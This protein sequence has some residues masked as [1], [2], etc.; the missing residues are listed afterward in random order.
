MLDWIT[1]TINSLGY[2]GIVFLMFLENLFPPIPSEVI[3]PLAG[4][5]T[6]QGRLSITFVIVAGTVGSVL[7]ALL[8][9]YIGKSFG[10]KRL[11]RWA[12]RH[13]KWLTISSKDIDKSKKWFNKYGGIAVFIGR[14]IPG[15]RTFISVPA[16]LDKMHL[17]PFL[18]YSTIGSVL[19]VSLL[20]FAGYI[21][22]R[23]YQL[24][25]K[26]LGPISSFIVIAL[27]VGFV[28]WVIKRRR[29]RKKAK[30]KND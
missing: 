2:W 28:F 13:G 19:W 10:E 21:L 14:L 12:D 25:E 20:T 5:T 3:M 30:A 4:F 8:W 22:G 9:Y 11:K 1:N 7:G 18:L 29:K 27:I 16:G 6:T 15:V 17:V 23:N 26:Y 24:V